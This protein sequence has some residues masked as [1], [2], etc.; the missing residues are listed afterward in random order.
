MVVA[1]LSQTSAPLDP[2]RRQRAFRLAIRHYADQLWQDKRTAVPALLGPAIGGILVWYCPPLVIAAALERFGEGARPELGDLLPYLLAFTALWVVGEGIWRL[3]IHFI[4]RVASSGSASLQTKGMDALLDKDLAFF[5]D[6]FAGALTKK[7]LS[8]GYSYDQ[9]VG[10]L[11]FRIVP[12]V[13]PIVFVSVVLWRYSPWIVAVLLGMIALTALVVMPLVVRRQ[14]L[15]DVREVASNRVAGHVA[16][17]IANADAVRLFSREAE[18]SATHARNVDEWRRR[19]LHSWD[20]QNQRVDLVTSPLY[21]ATNVLGVVLAVVLGDGGRLDLAA[22]FV[23]FTY[24][25]RV[26]EI[27][28]QFNEIYRN[29]ETHLSQAAQFTELLLDPPLVTDPPDP[30]VP[31]F[32]DAGVELDQVV[33][34]YPNRTEPL[35]AG[36]DLRIEPGQK[37]GLVGPS[38][39]GKSTLIRLLLRFAD[40][41]GGAIRLGGQD[42]SVIRQA[43]VRGQIAYVPQDPVM[44][45]RTL[46]DN[47]AF[48]RLDASE[49][50]IQAAAR[51][52][53]ADGFIHAL[54]QGYDTLVGERGVK[55]S[56][57]Q[58][59]RVAIA[60]AVL[61]A[62]PILV[63]DEATSSLDSESEHLIQQALRALMA[64]RTAIVVAH[65]LSTLQAMDR[66]VVL[67]DG[68]V[69][70]DGTHASLLAADGLY[71]SLWRQQSGGF[72]VD[73]SLEDLD[74]L[75]I[76][77]VDDLDDVLSEEGAA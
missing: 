61:R 39:A 12:N 13:V 47:V 19:A 60:R 53:N 5:Q 11:T 37:V 33:F 4:N 64:E 23:T 44:F 31:R 55:L 26:T 20:Y 72:L 42:I 2:A 69:V 75:D 24:Y 17:T 15:V 36:L 16:D 41:D 3:G 29:L 51:A 35:F 14:R 18:E 57:G 38:G 9:V 46:R 73:D 50:E 22:V 43:D 34:R 77:D 10:T 30:V 7:L 45:H 66:L 32:R 68:A 25:V 56:G 70:E 74:D 52:A 67:A 62:S 48:G 28:W 65:R 63:L 76:D 1:A 71:A 6:N 40:L 54:P 27:V 21:V 49:D 58:R 59:Q 8:Y